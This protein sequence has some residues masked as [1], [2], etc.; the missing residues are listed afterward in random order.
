L[1]DQLVGSGAVTFR[2]TYG[3]PCESSGQHPSACRCQ[4]SSQKT[5]GE[6]LP[7]LVARARAGDDSAREELFRM[8]VDRAVRTAY[9]VTGDWHLA[10]DA[11]Q[12]AFIRAFR[13]MKSLA[14]NTPFLPWF[15]RILVNEA[16]RTKDRMRT[17][18]WTNMLPS[19]NARLWLRTTQA[20]ESYP[21]PEE[22]VAEKEDTAAIRKALLSLEED[23][24]IPIALKYLMG[25]TMSEISDA[26]DLP[27]TTVKSRLFVGRRR[28]RDLLTQKG[29]TALGKV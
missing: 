12:E 15:T 26:L 5:P 28:L 4:N 10:E 22:I 3:E 7:D 24:R 20:A 8:H 17:F 2:G 25:L 19:N 11:T 29:G 6:T 23:L 9:L 13:F 27:L 14:P 16:R 18:R 1:S 21:S